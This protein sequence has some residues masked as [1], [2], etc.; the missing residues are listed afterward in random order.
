MK[1]SQFIMVFLIFMR[2]L[3]THADATV[4][5]TILA[6]GE[7]DLPADTPSGRLDTEGVFGFVG[8][9]AIS[10]GSGN[11]KGS[12]VALSREWVLTAGHNVDL[13]DDGLPDAGWNGTFEL[14]GYGS[15]SVVRAFTHPGFSGFA[16][17]SV[18]DDLALLQLSAPLPVGMG[19]PTLGK[20]AGIGD[21]I[22]LVGFG[23]SGYGSYGYTTN[24]SLT[25]RRYGSNV[26]DSFQL[27]EEGSGTVEIFRYDF[28]D[29]S[30]TGQPGGSLGND[31]ETII[32]PGDSGGAALRQTASGWELVGINTFT[33]GY[34][35]RFGDTGGGVLVE[36]YADW[37][38]LTTGIPEPGSVGLWV[39]S[40][41]VIMRRRPRRTSG[42]F[43]PDWETTEAPQ[44][45]HL[46]QTPTM[47]KSPICQL[48]EMTPF[49]IF[50]PQ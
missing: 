5:A 19:F 2:L 32:G 23:R 49:P 28:D 39:A 48:Q 44:M 25:D 30:T 21:V 20:G 42:N 45:R 8:A 9:L 46:G 3:A 40:L 50:D 27:D 47:E 33:E 43:S 35:G 16:N 14:P 6:G 37:I 15:F 24:A 34:G 7:T 36:P 38:Y 17:P 10:R 1:R 13:N 41:L 4:T 18:N 22:T 29:P 12:A 31:L 11:Y 26:I